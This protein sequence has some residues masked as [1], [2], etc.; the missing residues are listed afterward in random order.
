MRSSGTPQ[1][2]KCAPHSEGCDER[3]VPVFQRDDRRVVQMVVVVVGED[4][5]IELGEIG[6]GERAAR[7]NA[8]DRPTS[9]EKCGSP[10]WDR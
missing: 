7:T 5:R 10:K 9:A 6:E 1:Y 2:A 4:H 3:G 8:R